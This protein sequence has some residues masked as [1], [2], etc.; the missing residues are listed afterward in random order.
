MSCHIST[1][2]RRAR[3]RARELAMLGRIKLKLSFSVID[4]R[5]QKGLKPLEKK[6]FYLDIKNH[7]T[8]AKLEAKI[9]ELG[10]VSRISSL[11]VRCCVRVEL[12][13]HVSRF[14]SHRLSICQSIWCISGECANPP[15]PLSFSFLSSSLSLP[16]PSP[17]VRF[18]LCSSLPA[19]FDHYAY[20][21]FDVTRAL[22]LPCRGRD[23]K[24]KKFESPSLFAAMRSP[25][26]S[27]R[28]RCRVITTEYARDYRTAGTRQTRPRKIPRAPT[29]PGQLAKRLRIF[30]VRVYR[31]SRIN[32][33]GQIYRR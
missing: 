15:L 32:S 3:A 17:C 5:I 14:V 30:D 20:S 4:V 18:P 21:R 33:S 12:R 11:L 25:G 2:H 29:L 9:R 27:S 10:G 7:V 19:I 28:P 16:P 22:S 6:S 24:K 23:K 26:H 1:K 8:A 31:F 13:S